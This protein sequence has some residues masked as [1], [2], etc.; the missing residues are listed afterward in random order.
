MKIAFI[1]V[2]FL[3]VASH[4]VALSVP[5]KAVNGNWE[6]ARAANEGD[7]VKLLVVMKRSQE[8]L[9]KLEERFWAV[10]TPSHKDYGK[11]LSKEDLKKIMQV[12]AAHTKKVKDYLLSFGSEDIVI[13][14]MRMKMPYM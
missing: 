4:C 2:A 7:V 8:S 11:F 6:F 10:S 1:V 12:P 5:S 14:P 13:K 3:A 9:A